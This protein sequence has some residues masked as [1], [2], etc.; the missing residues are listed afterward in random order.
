MNGIWLLLAIS[1]AQTL[2][3]CSTWPLNI[4]VGA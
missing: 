4:I 2:G 3:T 1:G